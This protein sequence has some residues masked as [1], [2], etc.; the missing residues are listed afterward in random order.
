M[1]M[2]IELWVGVD[3]H[4]VGFFVF[5]IIQSSSFDQLI[6]GLSEDV[7]IIRRGNTITRTEVRGLYVIKTHNGR[8]TEV[9]F[10]A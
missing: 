2:G 3:V 9:V 7:Y 5:V 6:D 8:Q 1:G 10:L 4:L